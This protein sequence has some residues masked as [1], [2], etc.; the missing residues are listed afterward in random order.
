MPTLSQLIAYRSSTSVLPNDGIV[1]GLSGVTVPHNNGLALIDNAHPS[2]IGRPDP[3]LLERRY[4]DTDLCLPNLLGIMLYP[5]RLRIYL[6][7]L[8]LNAGTNLTLMI[9]DHGS[10]AS[11]PG[12]K[13]E[14]VLH[15]L[16]FDKGHDEE[17]SGLIS[18]I[19]DGR[20]CL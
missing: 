16:W 14:D 2:D 10:D 7:Y 11:G 5:P 20:L 18:S 12:I 1:N 19:V 4:G 6:T 17:G 8:L 15:R 13:G 9:E 3:S